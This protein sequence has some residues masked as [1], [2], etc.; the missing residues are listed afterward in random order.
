[1]NEYSIY[2]PAEWKAARPYSPKAFAA[3]ENQKMLFYITPEEMQ[4]HAKTVVDEICDGIEAR[5]FEKGR[6][7]GL[8][9]AGQANGSIDGLQEAA[10]QKVAQLMGAT[11]KPKKSVAELAA[12]AVELREEAAARGEEMTNVE[13]CRAAFEEAG[14]RWDVR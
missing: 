3:K 7:A 8:A 12:R 14:V 6:V 5:A 9:E 2:E 10:M 1:M 4:A 13:S 11:E